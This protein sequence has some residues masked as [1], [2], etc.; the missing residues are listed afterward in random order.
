MRIIRSSRFAWP[1]LIASGL[2]EAV[3]ATL[4]G[5]GLTWTI[6]P[7]FA[8]CLGISVGGLAL[9]MNHI[10]AGT[11][12][13]SWTGIGASATVVWAMATGAEAADPRR[14]ALII[15]L[16]G[17][18]AGLHFASGDDASEDRSAQAGN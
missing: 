5:A 11:A 14:I 9:A 15:V 13:A 10:P 2:F 6:F 3:W 16:I 1:L 18:V 7:I 8:I 17:C 4:L 12:Y